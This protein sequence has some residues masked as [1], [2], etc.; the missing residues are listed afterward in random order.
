MVRVSLSAKPTWEQVRDRL[1]TRQL[2]VIQ[3]QG[4]TTPSRIFEVLGF[5]L[6]RQC[7]PPW[8]NASRPALR[9]IEPGTG[10][11]RCTAFSGR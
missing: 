9:R 7:K 5:L 2:D 10:T 6:S 4:K 8:C 3:V 11:R 1:A